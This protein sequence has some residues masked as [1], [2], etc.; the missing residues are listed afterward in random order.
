MTSLPGNEG[1]NENVFLEVLNH[2]FPN[3]IKFTIEKEVEE[4]VLFLDILIIRSQEGI[5]TTVYRKPTHS[6]KY[7]EYTSHHPRHI[8]T[9][10][11]RGVVDRALA[12]CDPEYLEEELVHLQRTFE[13]N[14][15]PIHIINSTIQRKLEG[16]TRTKSPAPGL[17][18]V[19]PYYAGQGEKIKRL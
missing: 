18:L 17:R 6:D 4:K 8:M 19:L 10:I 16:S 12:I 2:E 1:G 14:G 7:V 3:V 15:Y 5:K 13:K 11:L 9:G